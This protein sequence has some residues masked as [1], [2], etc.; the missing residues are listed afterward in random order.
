M[1]LTAVK[2]VISLV[3]I[4]VKISTIQST[5]FNL[6]GGV[7]VCFSKIFWIFS[8]S[9]KYSSNIEGPYSI[10]LKVSNN[11]LYS[12]EVKLFFAPKFSSVFINVVENIPKLILFIFSWSDRFIW[13]NLL[14]NKKYLF[15]KVFKI[16]SPC[17]KIWFWTFSLARIVARHSF[18]ISSIERILLFLLL[19]LLLFLLLL[20]S[21]F[22]LFLISFNLFWHSKLNL[23]V[24]NISWNFFSFK[25]IFILLFSVVDGTKLAG[26][27]FCVRSFL[28]LRERSKL[29]LWR[30]LLLLLFVSIFSQ[31]LCI[32][33][34][35]LNLIVSFVE[36]ISLFI[37]K[38]FFI[39]RLLLLMLL[40]WLV[41]FEDKFV[42]IVV[43]HR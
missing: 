29:F 37:M 32:V 12:S 3:W 4:M 28:P 20:L 15:S 43:G 9:V 22:I 6:I 5:I 2:K 34:L 8:T 35:F 19:L 18:F 31:L 17:F 25:L 1:T 14:F 24:F 41:L 16:C 26:V 30:W 36:K 23:L 33:K 13:G 38:C 42:D 7:M 11:C 39:V 10:I 40:F 27:D 21:I